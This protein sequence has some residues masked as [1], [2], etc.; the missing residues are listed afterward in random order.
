MPWRLQ[1]IIRINVRFIFTLRSVQL[2]K[3]F[4]RDMLQYRSVADELS[5]EYILFPEFCRQNLLVRISVVVVNNMYEPIRSLDAVRVGYIIALV[6]QQPSD[7]AFSVV[8][9]QDRGKIVPPLEVNMVDKQQ[10]PA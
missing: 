9:G 4:D 2:S 7:P 3:G 1:L 8:L 6:E 5:G 10:T